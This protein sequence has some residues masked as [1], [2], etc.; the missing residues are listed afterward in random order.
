LDDGEAECPLAP[1][2]EWRAALLDAIKFM[3]I[4]LAGSQMR[5]RASFA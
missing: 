4:L 3:N 5:E 1:R 2:A